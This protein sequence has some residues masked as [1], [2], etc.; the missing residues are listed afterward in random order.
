MARV[1]LSQ[2]VRGCGDQCVSAWH[3][4]Q[5]FKKYTRPDKIP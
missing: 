5:M 1:C 4:L 2:E 3:Y